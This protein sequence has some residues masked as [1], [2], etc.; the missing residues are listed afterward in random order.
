MNLKQ[1]IHK[2]IAYFDLF[3]F[4]L[5]AEEIKEYLYNYSKPV[6]IKEIKG[7]LDEMTEEE[8]LEEL[9][10][11]YVL[12]GRG[13]IIETRKTRKFIAEKFWNRT[14][15]YGQYMRAVPFVRMVSV[16][17]NLSYDNPNQDS[18]I[19]LFIVIKPGHMWLSRLILTLILQFF[20]VR[21]HGNKV[22]GRFCLSFFITENALSM[23]KLQI[24]PED[25]YLA[26]W[27]KLLSPIYGENVYEEF[28]KQNEIWLE[29]KYGLKFSDEQK[30]HLY[31]DRVSGIKGFFE[32]I[33][34]GCFGNLIEKFLKKTF[35]KKTLHKMKHL[36][37]EASVIVSDDILKFHNHDKRREYF[38]KWRKII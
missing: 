10:D 21:R 11:F 13:G 35:K 7:T 19:D 30:K 9:K 1:S 26:Y 29:E 24:K 28:K 20:G 32:W 5:T 8:K 17:N 25:P 18:D 33:F 3:D 2:T 15:L 16:C 37:P 31:V 36:G 4:P 34:G 6:H 14:K 27:T 12:K 23:E 22:T 38:E